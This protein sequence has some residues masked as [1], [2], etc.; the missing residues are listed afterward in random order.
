M[1]EVK[2]NKLVENKENTIVGGML[3]LIEN[4]VHIVV[5]D[6]YGDCLL[7]SIQDGS[8][9]DEEIEKCT[10]NETEIGYQATYLGNCVIT[11]DQV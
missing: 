3:F 5:A 7:V 9:Y 10:I 4:I 6:A 2:L 8:L 1:N 11:V